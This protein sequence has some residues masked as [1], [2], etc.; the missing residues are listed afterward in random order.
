MKTNIKT[1]FTLYVCML[2]CTILFSSNAI[3][4]DDTGICKIPEKCQRYVKYPKSEKETL[5]IVNC[6]FY[7]NTGNYG[8]PILGSYPPMYVV[9]YIYNINRMPKKIIFK[10]HKKDTLECN[11]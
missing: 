3:A 2:L 9:P 1:F 11:F 10:R 5:L 6:T 7:E 8:E 4:N